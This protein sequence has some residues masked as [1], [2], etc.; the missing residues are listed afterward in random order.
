MCLCVISLS[1]AICLNPNGFRALEPF[2]YN[3]ECYCRK[4]GSLGNACQFGVGKFSAGKT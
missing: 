1:S 3:P 2:G 4:A